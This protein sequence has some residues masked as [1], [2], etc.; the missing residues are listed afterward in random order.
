MCIRYTFVSVLCFATKPLIESC[1]CHPYTQY[2]T[3]S[4][5]LPA[6]LLLRALTH[7]CCAAPCSA[8]PQPLPNKTNTN[9]RSIVAFC[10]RYEHIE[11]AAAA[12]GQVVGPGLLAVQDKAMMAPGDAVL[13][14]AYLDLLT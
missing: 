2:L 12:S 1:H 10:Q 8:T 13:L 4:S 11:R 5:P 3:P 7:P 14:I 9:N 6:C